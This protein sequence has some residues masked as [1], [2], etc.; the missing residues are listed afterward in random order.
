[1]NLNSLEEAAAAHSRRSCVTHVELRRTAQ[2]IDCIAFQA[3]AEWQKEQLKY[4]FNAIQE[5]HKCLANAD[6]RPYERE[7]L[8]RAMEEYL[9]E[10]TQD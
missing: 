9:S 8:L 5:V 7:M 6:D 3:G 2:E 10:P 4:L 1:M